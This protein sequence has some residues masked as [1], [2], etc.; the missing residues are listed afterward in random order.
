MIPRTRIPSDLRALAACQAGV[1]S[2]EQVLGLGLTDRVVERLIGQEDWRR[3]TRGIYALSE[4]TWLQLAW[5]GVLLGG[6]ASVLGFTSAAY[7][8]GLT[9]TPPQPISVFVG[10]SGRVERDDRWQ[11]CRADRLGR[12]DP[13]RTRVAQTIAD[14]SGLMDADD[15]T[16]LLAEAIGSRRTTPDDILRIARQTH[17][18]RHRRLLTDILGDVAAGAHSPLEMRYLRAVER[19]HGLPVAVRQ[20]SPSGR[21]RTDAW[22]RDYRVVVELD[23]DPYHRGLAR[24]IDM[25]RDNLHGLDGITTLRFSWVHV[26]GDPCAVAEQVAA[27]LSNHGWWGQLAPCSRC[28]RRFV[29]R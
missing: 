20:A 3:M 21:F 14:L 7:L 17:R 4:E 1:V 25:T 19:P 26:V 9:R 18:L 10:R 5:A 22:Y 11:F 12:G 24:S 6:P 27:A 15:L 2:R 28:T 23:G 29:H 16:T 8:H 13:P